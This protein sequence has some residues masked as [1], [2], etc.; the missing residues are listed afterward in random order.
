[1]NDDQFPG[2]VK[3][4]K[5]YRDDTGKSHIIRTYDEV[6][7]LCPVCYRPSADGEIHEHCELKLGEDDI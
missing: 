1:M 4:M 3:S 7:L 5:I 6:K 2:T